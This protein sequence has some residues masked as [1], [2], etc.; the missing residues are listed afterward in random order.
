MNTDARWQV[1]QD[2]EFL[3]HGFEEDELVIY[4]TGSGHTHL[5]SSLQSEA[6]TYLQQQP[7]TLQDLTCHLINVFDINA[8]SEFY[9]EIEKLLLSLYRF[10]IVEQCQK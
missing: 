10:D 1:Q 6:F 8:D 3:T 9:A 5:L 2:F 4:H 7:S